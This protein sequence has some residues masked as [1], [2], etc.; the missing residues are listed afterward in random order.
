M[1]SII[2][3]FQYFKFFTRLHLIFVFISLYRINE[4]QELLKEDS[5]DFKLFRKQCFRGI[6][7]SLISL[8]I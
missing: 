1:K 5:I 7:L 8:R 6:T 3:I 4:L 2:I